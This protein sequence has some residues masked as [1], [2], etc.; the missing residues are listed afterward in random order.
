MGWAAAACAVALIL[1]L[2]PLRMF[3]GPEFMARGL[4]PQTLE[5]DVLV[6][7]VSQ[8][9]RPRAPKGTIRAGDE[10]AFAYANAPGYRKLLIFG[11]DEHRHVYW[12][13]PAWSDAALDP[14][15]IEIARGSDV[16]EIPEAIRQSIDG[17]ELTVYAVFTN[18]DLSVRRIEAMVE[19]AM[20]PSDP[21]PLR[22]SF[23]KRMHFDV[24]R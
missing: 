24:E 9:Q 13:H 6:Y 17:R 14:H 12:Y 22:A 5:P 18:E 16:R 15:G 7:E 11:V 4:A 23:Q 21:L 19:A 2:V 10:L 1:F 3:R 20:S 8:G